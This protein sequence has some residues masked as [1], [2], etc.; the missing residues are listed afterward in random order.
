MACRFCGLFKLRSRAHR[1]DCNPLPRP[2]DNG[3]A[4]ALPETYLKT[5]LEQA[6]RHRDAVG[7][8]EL[9]DGTK[10]PGLAVSGGGIRSAVFSLGVLQAMS[11]VDVLKQFSYLSTVSGGSYI[12]AFYGSLFVPDEL[13]AGNFDLDDA[14]FA[15]A[16]RRASCTLG[17]NTPSQSENMVTPIAFLRDNCNYLAP[18]GATDIL[19]SM[20]FSTRNW[21]A[22][23]Y[24][25]GVALLTIL[26]WLTLVL[27][28][29]TEWLNGLLKG[30]L[31]V[32][33][34]E[35]TNWWVQPLM[36][37]LLAVAIAA[38]VL[39]PLS[40]A[41]WLTQNFAQE[42]G[43]V[44]KRLPFISVLL[45]TLTALGALF[46]R[47]YRDKPFRPQ[48]DFLIATCPVLV[49]SCLLV[50]ATGL[51]GMAY[52][53]CAWIYVGG[54]RGSGKSWF[55]GSVS[56]K[57]NA[58]D[59][60]AFVDRVRNALTNAYTTPIHRRQ[61]RLLTG[62]LQ[63]ALWAAAIAVIDALGILAYQSLPE[64]LKAMH[65]S[66][67]VTPTGSLGVL[68]G[69]TAAMWSAA[70]FLLSQGTTI[71]DGAKKVP[72]VVLASVA[73]IIAALATLIF[74]SAVAHGVA[75]F[76][77]VVPAQSDSC[78][79]HP[80]VS[81]SC[82]LT[83]PR[84]A[85]TPPVP[86]FT[87]LS[88]CMNGKPPC[89]GSGGACTVG[90]VNHDFSIWIMVVVC[91]VLLSLAI[92]DGLC[93][94]FLNL[95]TYQRLYSNRL[96]R[97]FLGATNRFRLAVARL[98]DVTSLIGGDSITM[99]EYF[100][101]KSCAPVHLINMTINKT[102]DWDSSL[103][104][105]GARGLS[106]SVGP[107][108]ATVGA[109]LGVLECDWEHA[110]DISTP[111]TYSRSNDKTSNI[112]LESLTLGDWIAISGAAVSTGLGQMTRP[113]YSLLLGIANIRLGYW[114]DTNSA[115][116]PCGAENYERERVPIPDKTTPPRFVTETLFGTQFC[117]KSELLGEFDG[118][119][120]RRWYLTDG[121]HF[122]NT[123]AYELLRRGLEF[124]VVF[125]NGCDEHYHFDD[126]ANLIRHAR[127]DFSIEIEESEERIALP[128]G[129][130][131]NT[132][133]IAKSFEEFA[134]K[135][136]LIAVR[137]IT[138]FLDGHN[139]QLIIIK[140]RVTTDAPYDVRQYKISNAQFPNDSTSNQFFN[141]TQWESY[142]ELGYSQ[143]I[144]L[145]S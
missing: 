86:C 14:S 80:A 135:P 60:R 8:T 111:A 5:E 63:I 123:G 24:V 77:D 107:A 134:K 75:V 109:R 140:P 101:P 73:A 72:K 120:G 91:V 112:W 84:L 126:V 64:M 69:L 142:R 31:K 55:P 89:T 35:Q 58:I 118:P 17:P 133:L 67:S 83:V 79:L 10:I 105:R 137:L 49:I 44:S 12:G 6:A 119:R 132:A 68:A 16:A 50:I 13:R 34:L 54:R 114:W 57:S 96:T 62:P 28:W 18:N 25:I 104:Q 30:W 4:W 61:F 82:M 131:M 110:D 138:H 74:W 1:G 143:G 88:I 136:T 48:W 127:V 33:W 116:F 113:E 108:G 38:F 106:M 97:T 36:P 115:P 26:L 41:Y 124:I 23:Q 78:T 32:S 45:V 125:D 47:F 40:R 39:S 87:P 129:I 95:S 92:I 102:I 94:Q 9:N 22:V 42:T 121:G 99:N 139:G 21:L 43:P 122:E 81:P 27:S 130:R 71:A 141:D 59:S 51:L 7:L 53:F 65:V 145:F 100:H 19:Q 52:L 29:F 2:V 103:V 76:L 3:P 93:I 15:A 20:V 11:D 66:N 70:K 117:L 85:A 56:A 37:A 46:V 144:A 128:R 98:R 90:L